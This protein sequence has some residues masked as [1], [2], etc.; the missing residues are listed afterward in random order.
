MSSSRGNPGADNAESELL[1]PKHQLPAVMARNEKT[2]DDGFWKKMVRVAGKI[3]FA[4]EAATAWYCA[5]DPETPTRVRA[6]LLAA[7]A[8]FVMPA[9][10]IPDIVAAFGF[11]DDATVLMAALGLVSSYMKPRHREAA[12]KALGL[13]PAD[14]KN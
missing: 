2:V 6:T 9:D 5:R 8:Y 10:F 14:E 3:P 13:P 1:D 7:L 12:R 4:E 11:T